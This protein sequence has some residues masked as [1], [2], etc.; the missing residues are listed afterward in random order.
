MND[1]YAAV[2]QEMGFG[3]DEPQ[4]FLRL[5]NDGDTEVVILRGIETKDATQNEIRKGY[6]KKGK[7]VEYQFTSPLSGNERTHRTSGQ[8][9]M[10]GL[11]NATS[12]ERDAAGFQVVRKA[13]PGEP[14]KI[15]RT[16]SGSDTRLNVTILSQEELAAYIKENSSPSHSVATPGS[17]SSSQQQEP[18]PNMQQTPSGEEQVNIDD[19]PF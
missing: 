11:K 19:I 2:E 14:I 6:D 5:K 18:E 13:M 4:G 17:P 12:Y 1:P 16:G 15:V 8:A 10:I 7:T 9:L 3:G